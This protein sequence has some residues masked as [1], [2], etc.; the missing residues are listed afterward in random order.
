[1]VYS[2][3]FNQNM[4]TSLGVKWSEELNHGDMT[5]VSV[6]LTVVYQDLDSITL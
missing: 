5:F 6:A 2:Q 1:M 3:N 4:L